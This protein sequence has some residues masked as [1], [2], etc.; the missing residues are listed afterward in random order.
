MNGERE[1]EIEGWTLHEIAL[2][3]STNALASTLPAWHAV[4]ADIQTAGRGRFQRTWVSDKG[5]LWLSAV[6]PAPQRKAAVASPKGPAQHGLPM[7]AGLAVCDALAELGLKGYRMR[8]P[9][10]V[11]MQDRKLA[12]LLLEQ[13]APDRVVAGI[14]VNVRNQPAVSDPALHYQATRLVDCLPAPPDLTALATLV[15][16]HL[17]LVAEAASRLGFE[18]M[19]PRVNALWRAPRKV[20]LLLDDGLRDGLFTNVNEEGCLLL[21]DTAGRTTAYHPSQVRH[22]Q[23]I[24][25]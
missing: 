13:F 23:E 5:G 14:G 6:L 9:N 21:Q 11:L 18:A 16:R 12:G 24:L 2:A 7:V 19:L 10:D 20:Q 17:R 8:W 4:R 15:L 22:V 25:T 3:D 1:V